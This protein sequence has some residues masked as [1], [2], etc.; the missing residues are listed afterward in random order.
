MESECIRVKLEAEMQTCRTNVR[1]GRGRT[2]DRAQRL[3]EEVERRSVGSESPCKEVGERRASAGQMYRKL[4][5]R[6]PS[7]RYPF[8]TW[9]NPQISLTSLCKASILDGI[10]DRMG[11]QTSD[12]SHRTHNLFLFNFHFDRRDREW[13]LSFAR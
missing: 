5:S 8:L 12:G 11:R 6:S 13:F 9:C 4:R 10:S 1:E 7:T 3:V 2:D